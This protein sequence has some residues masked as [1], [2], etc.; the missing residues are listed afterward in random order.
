MAMFWGIVLF[1][2]YPDQWTVIGA[3][4]IGGAGLYVWHRETKATHPR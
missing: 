1:D 3:L 2:Q 4:V